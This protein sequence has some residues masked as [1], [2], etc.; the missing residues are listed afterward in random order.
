M[1]SG[2]WVVVFSTT[3]NPSWLP[4]T[5]LAKPGLIPDSVGGSDPSGPARP[6][7]EG[8]PAELQVWWLPECQ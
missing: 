8:E 6:R 4:G 2:L 3:V 1:W 7:N 5:I